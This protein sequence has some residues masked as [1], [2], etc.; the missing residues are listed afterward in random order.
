MQTV[1]NLTL[2]KIKDFV[3]PITIERAPSDEVVNKRIVHQMKKLYKTLPYVRT[4]FNF[5][6]HL[7]KWIS[8]AKGTLPS[9]I[10]WEVN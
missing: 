8:R 5:L 4:I 10:S 9:K 7:P 6:R 2:K 1:T 3:E